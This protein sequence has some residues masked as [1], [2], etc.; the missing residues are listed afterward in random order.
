MIVDVH[1]RTRHD[2]IVLGGL[3]VLNALFIV[4]WC[5]L[6]YYS[7][8]HY[9]D[10]H[11]LWKVREM[12]I[13]EYVKDMYFTRSGRFVGYAVNGVKSIVTNALGF[14]QLWAIFYY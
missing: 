5:I 9:D 12:S 14:H 4:Y 2:K 11:F 8:L 10:L 1:N 3:I 7:P 6:T 13:F